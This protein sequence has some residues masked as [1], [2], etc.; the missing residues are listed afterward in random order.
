MSGETVAQRFD[1]AARS[2]R[3]C[4]RVGASA[5]ADGDDRVVPDTEREGV[6][7]VVVGNG[8]VGFRFLEQLTAAGVT[9]DI[10]V[11]G[12][13]PCPAYDRVRLTEGLLR[14]ALGDLVLASREWYDERG[15]EL[16]TGDPVIA[17]DREAKRVRS[18]SGREVAY[19]VLVL[20][21][22]S[23]PRVPP[24]PGADMDEVVAYRTMRDAE[25]IRARA[26]DAERAVVLGG[27]LLGLEAAGALAGRPD[28]VTVVEAA[29]HLMPRQLDE[30]GGIALARA[31]AEVGIRVEVGVR[32]AAITRAP[33]GGLCVALSDGRQLH[34]DLV[35]MALGVRARDEIARDAGLAVAA[36]TP[37]GVVV[38]DQL[39][40]SDPSIYAVGECASHRG[41]TYGLLA[42]G[43]AMADALAARLGGARARFRGGDT[44]C[45][46][47]LAGIDVCAL[48]DTQGRGERVTFA[49][50]GISRTLV[51][52]RGR[53]VGA[54]IVGPW[55]RRGR[56]TL[57][58]AARERLRR[59]ALARFVR[60]EDPWPEGDAA[61][62]RLVDDALV[63]ACVG[64]RCGQIRSAIAAGSAAV[65]A[66]G[67]ATGAGTRC[68]S[69]A[70]VVASL[71]GAAAPAPSRA[72][73]VALAALSVLAAI[74]CLAFAWPGPV[75]A[76][77]IEA[78]GYRFGELWR[79]S[80]TKQITGYTLVGIAVLGL[81]I[82]A[83]KRTRWLRGSYRGYRV[84]H[85]ACGVGS[86]A[87]VAAHTGLSAGHNL[88]FALLAL[89]LAVQASGAVLGLAA[90][91]EASTAGVA[92]LARRA[93]PLT[94]RLH[95]LALWGVPALLAFHIL[96]VYYY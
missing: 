74:G 9:D 90:A 39:R 63:C 52:R 17:I 47:K 57:A 41:T 6:A 82:S 26:Q 46:L 7:V 88:N 64:V 13:E 91:V 4:E 79:D 61:R 45:S 33:S 85:A 49:A 22:G 77:S 67:A 93:R 60:G 92:A 59:R 87:L 27:G 21:T 96:S 80:T 28:A 19:D 16:H 72:P 14:D 3:A 15:I 55:S 73:A 31:L 65:D 1:R 36:T 66:V 42:P 76:D 83:R 94:T 68:G 18:R 32:A 24:I 48:G 69:C 53:L 2:E 37:G 89:F 43:I 34:G 81:L 78:A 75:T 58:V 71:C 54:E 12:E 40:T 38:D 84:L 70:P 25:R 11:F 29:N 51:L 35:V 44:S 95:I 8:M 10:T 56:A 86:L 23:S 50:G 62:V 5:Y 20:A 30:A